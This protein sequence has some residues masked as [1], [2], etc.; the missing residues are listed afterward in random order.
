MDSLAAHPELIRRINSY[1][2]QLFSMIV[3]MDAELPF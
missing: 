1:D 2:N 3:K